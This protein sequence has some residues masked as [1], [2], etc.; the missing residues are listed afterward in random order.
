MGTFILSYLQTK[1]YGKE[2][3]TEDEKKVLYMGGARTA[4][5]NVIAGASAAT[6]S[7]P[8][9]PNAKKSKSKY[10]TYSGMKTKHLLR[11]RRTT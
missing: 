4:V 9:W 1:R 5:L 8:L 10:V 7:K 6:T 3:L 11:D 2:A